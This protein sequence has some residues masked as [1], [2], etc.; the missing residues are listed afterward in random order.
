MVTRLLVFLAWMLALLAVA[1]AILRPSGNAAILIVLIGALPL[2]N[3]L[4]DFLSIG[5]TRFALRW[6]VRRISFWTVLVGAGDLLAGAILF[7]GLGCLAVAYAQ[8]LNVVAEAPLLPLGAAPDGSD[9]LFAAI[10]SDPAAYWWLYATFLST[11]LP[12][13]IHLAIVPFAL[14]PALMVGGL[15]GWLADAIEKSARHYPLRLGASLLLAAWF[16]VSLTAPIVLFVSIGQW[17]AAEHPVWGLRL[18]GLFESF[19]RL[20]PGS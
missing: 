1:V 16:A 14:G 13:A 4:F 2:V 18:L 20:L 15:R 17:M 6:G 5:V 11:L 10:R 7:V 8:L 19:H 9:G 12:T 3:A